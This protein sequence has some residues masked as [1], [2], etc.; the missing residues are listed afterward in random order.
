LSQ[1]ACI[2]SQGYTGGCCGS[3]TKVESGSGLPGFLNI[4]PAQHEVFVDQRHLNVY[5]FRYRDRFILT[6]SHTMYAG[7]SARDSAQWHYLGSNA[8]RSCD[9]K[10]TSSNQQAA[11]YSEYGLI[12][13]LPF[14][15]T[16]RC[17]ITH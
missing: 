14:F 9:W 7:L 4:A 12:Q 13:F 3:R 6:A 1:D 15:C 11:N 8:E 16:E 2:L 10:D 17:I 5:T